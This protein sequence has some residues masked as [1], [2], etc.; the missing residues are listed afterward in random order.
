[1]EAKTFENVF[2]HS[3]QVPFII[4]VAGGTASGKTTVCREI[5]DRLSDRRVVLIALDSFYRELTPEELEH[6][7]RINFDHPDAFDF[8]LIHSTLRDMRERKPVKIPE[9]D[10]KTYARTGKFIEIQGDVEV[11]LFEGILV[12]H[13]EEMRSMMDLKI[14]VQ[15]DADVRLIRRIRR[16]IAERG[17]DLESVLAQ[18]HK[19]VKPMHE[20]F[21]TTTKQHAHIIIP[22]GGVEVNEVAI[23]LVLM[24]IHTR[25]NMH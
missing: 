16:D 10:F 20:Q 7:E 18:Y 11:V 9:Y 23:N 2:T 8:D 1:M 17:R 22:H 25:L 24:H 14:Y 15:A 19:S 3:S 13:T 6:V 12:F 5:L 21:I 4:G